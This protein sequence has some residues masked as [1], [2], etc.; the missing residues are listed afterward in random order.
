MKIGLTV[1]GNERKGEN[2]PTGNSAPL[3]P[4]GMGGRNKR[5]LLE[6]WFD[7]HLMKKAIVTKEGGRPTRGD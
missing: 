1:H 4:S 3:E 6:S 7:K 2:N 5:D